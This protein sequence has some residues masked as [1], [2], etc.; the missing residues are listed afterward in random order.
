MSNPVETSIV[1]TTMAMPVILALG[2]LGLGT[3]VAPMYAA[4]P[5]ATAESSAPGNGRD[6]GLAT[7]RSL[8]PARLSTRPAP[9]PR[10]VQPKPA[11]KRVHL[12][13][14]AAPSVAPPPPPAP[15]VRP[16]AP[17][18]PAPP[19]PMPA[20]RPSPSPPPQPGGT[21]NNAYAARILVLVNAAR[22]SNGLR[23]LALSSCANSYAQSW[24]PHLAA[25]HALVHQSMSALLSGCGAR[26]A[27]E[28]IAYGNISADAM[29]AMWMASPEHRANLLNPAYGY[30]GIGAVLGANGIWYA[31]QDFLGY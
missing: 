1:R 15:V 29:E 22:A 24:A 11:A 30:I 14:P 25:I 5:A 3:A 7:P 20:P 16:P 13:R 31:V 4:H 17:V 10:A 23:P 8:F 6:L 26:A 19:P 21:L 27:G 28:N 2:V 18:P 12:A 9:R